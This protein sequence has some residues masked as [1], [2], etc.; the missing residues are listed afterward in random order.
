MTNFKNEA[1]SITRSDQLQ[2]R[3]LLIAAGFLF[4]GYA[5]LTL[6]PAVRSHSWQVS[7]NG[8]P[9]VGF[10]AWGIVFIILHRRT[11]SILP[12]RDPYLLPVAA[13]WTGMG[14]LMIWRLS[15]EFGIRQT[16]WLVFTGAVG[17]ALLS[18][19]KLPEFLQKY[20]YI[21]LLIAFVITGLTFIFGVFPSG[22]GPRLWL[23]AF[24]LYLQPSEPLK[25]L[26]IIYLSAYLSE[27]SPLMTGYATFLFPTAVMTGIALLL[28]IAQKD[29]GTTLILTGIYSVMLYLSTGK[30][31]MVGIS[32]AVVLIAGVI[33]FYTFDVV[34]LRI[35]AWLN[36]W[37]DPTG[38]SYQIVQSLIAIASGRLFGSGPGLGSPS[39]VPVAH[40]DFIFTAL[41]EE[42]GLF[43]AIIILVLLGLFASR[44]L[45]CAINA[46][47]R[48]ER[49]L[50]AGITAFIIGQALLIIGGNI[51]MLPL[52]GVTLPFISYGGSSLTVSMIALFLLLIISHHPD[53]E[54]TPLS[55]SKPY[56][57]ILG[58]VFVL[59]FAA[60]LVTG[61]WSVVRSDNLIGR[62]DNPRRTI[63]DRYVQRGSILDRNS[64]LINHT[65]GSS[66]SMTRVTDYTPLAPIIGYTHPVYG[67]TS[68]ESSY[69]SYL[70]GLAGYSVPTIL[71]NQILYNQPPKGLDI[72][73]TIDLNVQEEVDAAMGNK[74]GAAVVLNANT[75]EILAMAS[76]P[77]FD[78]T[79]LDQI[80]SSLVADA[81]KPLLNRAAAGL[82]PPGR[83]I[84]AFLLAAGQT[85][86]LTPD[87][88]NNYSRTSQD[89]VCALPV[90]NNYSVPD[91][92]Q[93]GCGVVSQ[94]FGQ[95]LGSKT[96]FNLFQMLGF[97]SPPD[98]PIL[99]ADVTLPNQIVDLSAASV[100]QGELQ[101]TPLQMALAAA[102]L[103]N[104]GIRPQPQLV[105][106]IKNPSGSWQVISYPETSYRAFPASSAQTAASLLTLPG[107]PAWGT[108]GTAQSGT[109]TTISWFIGGSLPE[110]NGMPFSIAI[111][112]EKG[113]PKAAYDTGV[114]VIKSLENLK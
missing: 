29:L 6:A 51:R 21:W 31:R 67:Q 83:T 98:L 99:T 37:L 107:I 104:G 1:K 65:E 77:Y 112:V 26:L 75:G 90:P 64:Q 3:L 50:A 36:P 62:S 73:T 92:I 70:R 7:L 41:T 33:G 72:R 15:P 55:D 12:E 101:I 76:H 113:T 61:W 16:I 68:L 108:V 114:I 86:G 43:T 111:L 78:P 38:R 46:R 97:F 48:Y 100:G 63:S 19:K 82:Y 17:F 88:F 74:N 54:P 22:N 42:G 69:D 25:I 105:T 106:S 8:L 109:D 47:S 49:Y 44:G 10:A 53:E 9:W 57:Y 110:W 79:Q 45:M 11:K 4:F 80:W 84:G 20:K 40:S 66:G 103:S 23:E 58:G 24:G 85:S 93:N 81:N 91:L 32:A 39:L 18:V 30:K 71:W 27:K 89:T 94:Y 102:T 95:H 59:L 5:G 52:T 56:H 87:S 96:I 2:F 60:G 28:L 35:D 13:L 34:R 14:M